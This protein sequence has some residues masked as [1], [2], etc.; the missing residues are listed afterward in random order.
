[1]A[2]VDHPRFAEWSASLQALRDAADSYQ[3]ATAFNKAADNAE[4]ERELRTAL[5]ELLAQSGKLDG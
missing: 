3:L 1:M 4:L 2:L 5:A